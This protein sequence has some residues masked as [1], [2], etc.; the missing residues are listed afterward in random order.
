MRNGAYEAVINMVVETQPAG[1]SAFLVER[2]R[3]EMKRPLP[4]RP[5]LRAAAEFVVDRPEIDPR[6]LARLKRLTQL[7]APTE[8]LNMAK[9]VHHFVDAFLEEMQKSQARDGKGG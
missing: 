1:P 2:L 3:T 5:A 8:A 9:H 7:Y 4:H 6:P